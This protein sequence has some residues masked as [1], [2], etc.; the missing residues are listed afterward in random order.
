M[1]YQTSGLVV[2]IAVVAYPYARGLSTR[3]TLV[4]PESRPYSCIKN[5]SVLVLPVWKGQVT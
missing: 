3:Q 1:W 2:N 5:P 4:T